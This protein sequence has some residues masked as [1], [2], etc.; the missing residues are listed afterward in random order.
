MATVL[1]RIPHPHLSSP[2]DERHPVE[3]T[4]AGAALVIG[5]VAAFSALFPSLHM[6]SSW[7]GVAG[8]VTGF[9]AQLL[10]ATTNERWFA[11]V[12]LIASFVGFMLGQAHGGFL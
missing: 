7:A 10:S 3:A 8:G 9:S 2:Q 4:L 6:V 11:I 5:L 12:G 1:T